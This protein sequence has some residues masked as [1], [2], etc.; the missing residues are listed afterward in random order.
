M[1]NHP[2]QLAIIGPT[3][4]GKSALAIKIAKELDADILSLDSLAIYRQ[5]DIASAKPTQEEMEGIIH[6][7]I[8]LIDP[9]ESFDVTIYI[10]LYNEI[11][12]R[13]QTHDRPLIIVG[14]TSFYLQALLK[15]IS[16]IPKLDEDGYAYVLHLLK[17]KQKAYELLLKVDPQYMS[18]IASN[19]SYRIE[20]A[21]AIYVASNMPPSLY[22]KL[23]PPRPIIQDTLAIYEISIEKECLIDRIEKRTAMMIQNGLIDEV[24]FLEANY[25]RVPHCM[26]AIGIKETLDFLDGNIDQKKLAELISI[27]TRQLAKRQNTFNRT[28][29][30]EKIITNPEN[31]YE[32]IMRATNRTQVR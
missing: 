22:F 18:N 28:Q 29:F 16:N 20:K 2:K 3:A 19:D 4:S 7:G 8:D 32:K 27:H 21:L 31:I 24:R 5:I 1:Y 10:Q 23:N 15:G 17:D 6:Y 30:K 13:V 25:S 12:K 9:N 14:G 26:K 11:Y